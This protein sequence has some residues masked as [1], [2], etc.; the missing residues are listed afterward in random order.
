MCFLSRQDVCSRSAMLHWMMMTRTWK[1]FIL[2]LHWMQGYVPWRRRAAAAHRNLWHDLAT[3]KKYYK[4][5]IFFSN[6]IDV[7]NV[8]EWGA[9]AVL[10][11]QERPNLA[12]NLLGTKGKP[13][14]II[15]HH[16]HSPKMPIFWKLE[17][18]IYYCPV[19]FI[20]PRS[21]HSL[22]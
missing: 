1:C 19:F 6:I 8:F 21:D 18:T 4:W 16:F 9:L 7:A 13:R 17:Q 12:C 15:F 11:T 22:P 3:I 2:W 5:Q 14:P 20:G 10:G